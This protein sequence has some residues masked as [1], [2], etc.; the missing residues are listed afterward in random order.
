MLVE[1]EFV[2]RTE[3]RIVSLSLGC[4]LAITWVALV[5]Q[6]LR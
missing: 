4:C 3:A 5:G 6:Y 2:R 1:T